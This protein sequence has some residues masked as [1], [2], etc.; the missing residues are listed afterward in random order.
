MTEETR[1]DDRQWSLEQDADGIAWLVFDK[2]GASANSLSR[3]AMEELDARLA[4]VERMAPAGLVIASAKSGFIAGADVKEFGKVSSPDEA[5]PYVRAAHAI[6]D[7]LE[8]LSCPTVASINGYCLGG[9]L[10]LALACRYR[11]CADDATVVLGVPEVLLGIHPG[12]GGTVRLV[13]LIGVSAAMDMMLTGRNLRPEKALRIGLVDSV[14]PAAELSEAAAGLVRARPRPAQAPLRE[15]LLSTAP[16][17]GFVANKVRQQVARRARPEHYPAPYAIVELWRKHGANPRTAYEAEAQSVARLVCTQTSRNLVRVFFLQERLKSLGGSPVPRSGHVHVVGAGVMGGDIAAW[18]ALR[19][20]TV[21][22]QDRTEDLVRPAIERARALFEKRERKPGQAAAWGE[23]L[24][25]DVEGAGLCD[26]DV[27]IE[28]IIEDA[29]AKRA[30]YAELEPRMKPEALLATNTSSITLDSLND[31]LA[32]PGRLVG[33][34]FFNPVVQMPL[35]EVVESS[36]TT[37]AVHTAAL[38]YT[39]GMDKLPLPCRSAPGFLVNRVLMPYLTEAMLAAQQGIPLA[40]IDQRAEE[41]GMPIG[42]IELADTVGLDVCLHVGRILAEASGRPAPE[43]LVPL[44][45]AGSLGRKSGKGLYEWQAGKAV[46]PSAGSAAAPED[47]ADRL[48]LPMVNEAVAVLREGVVA[49]EDLVDA[50]VI[51]GS[52]FAPFR[53]GPLRYARERGCGEVVARLQELEAVHGPRFRPDPGWE[54]F[55]GRG[56]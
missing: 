22:L 24:R 40:L 29:D 7:R 23:R 8:R 56:L 14:V 31:V 51:F 54:Q 1:V 55:A 47:L 2:P 43:A 27:V 48:L 15:R 28:A 36:R 17:R 34:H 33:L 38:A 18:C 16:L 35:V 10:E 50:G 5:V 42:P 41:F 11:V 21:T 37:A 4:E 6:L 45:E 53:G 9:G 39:R 12:F 46:K 49:D 30:L 44:V 32:D 13:R 52:G 26:A 19:G 20:F 3:A 25:P